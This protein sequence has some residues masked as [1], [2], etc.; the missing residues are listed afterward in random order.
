MALSLR[1]FEFNILLQ[2]FSE[3]QGKFSEAINTSIVTFSNKFKENCVSV[4]N[5]LYSYIY[6]QDEVNY[7]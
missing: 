6:E 5:E 4:L 1:Q 7:A 3:D 2:N